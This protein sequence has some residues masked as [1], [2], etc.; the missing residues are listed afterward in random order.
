M[1]KERK[2][3]LQALWLRLS[4][5][6]IPGQEDTTGKWKLPVSLGFSLFGGLLCYALE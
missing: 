3:F 4:G 5:N 1:S 2:G 6:C